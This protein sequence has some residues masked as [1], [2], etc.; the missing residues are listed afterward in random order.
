[1]GGKLVTFREWSENFAKIN[2]NLVG[3]AE[4]TCRLNGNRLLFTKDENVFNK[5][6]N[7]PSNVLYELYRDNFDEIQMNYQHLLNEFDSSKN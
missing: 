1:M 3:W 2:Y 7:Q 5:L 4:I 6:K